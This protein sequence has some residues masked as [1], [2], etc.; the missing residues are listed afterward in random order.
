[1]RTPS[2]KTF[3]WL[4]GLASAIVSI[5]GVVSIARPYIQSEDPPLAGVAHVKLLDAQFAQYTQQDQ[6]RWQQQQTQQQFMLRQVLMN[7]YRYWSAQYNMAQQSLRNH[8]NDP[9][10]LSLRD[11]ALGQMRM[12]APQLGMG[13]QTP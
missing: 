10:A 9:V 8:P 1:M 2:I 11:N 3:I 13:A 12:L 7:D 5:A 6:F 4:G